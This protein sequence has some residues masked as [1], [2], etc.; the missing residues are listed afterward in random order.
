MKQIGGRMYKR[1]FVSLEEAR[2]IV[3]AIVDAHAKLHAGTRLEGMPIAAAVVDMYGEPICLIRQDEAFPLY[4]HMAV[5]KAY[6]ATR[7]NVNT[8]DFADFQKTKGREM[9]YWAGND[10][11]LTGIE[12]G[13]VIR[14]PTAGS[15]SMSYLESVAS[16]NN[17]GGI[18]VSGLPSEED[19]RM[20]LAGLKAFQELY[21]KET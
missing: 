4:G 18:G 5:C 16:L 2:T 13:V 15:E 1:D 10:N 7:M 8:R 12:G 21:S 20:A 9:I 6:T 14:K 19:E 3:D 11:R 17:L